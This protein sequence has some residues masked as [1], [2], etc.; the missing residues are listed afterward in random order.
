MP[1]VFLFLLAVTVALGCSC[2]DLGSPCSGL[3]SPWIVLAAK[4]LTNSTNIPGKPAKMLVEEPF[5]NVPAGL[6]EFLA[7]TSGPC[8]YGPLK[9]GERYVIYTHP[10]GRLDGVYHISMCSHTFAIRNRPRLL[11]ALRNQ[12]KGG[13]PRLIGRTLPVAYDPGR[14][15]PA[16]AGVTVT[17]RGRDI[18]QSTVSDAA[19]SY[20]FQNLRNG[21]YTIQFAKPGFLPPPSKE[22][23]V[24]NGQ[25]ALSSEE[26]A[27]NG[28]ISG[29]VRSGNGGPLAGIVVQAVPALRSAGP[30][31]ETRTR[32]DGSYTLPGLPAGRYAV[33]VNA[34]SDDQGP[35]PPTLRAAVTLSEHQALKNVDVTLPPP[36]TPARL[37]VRV[38][39]PGGRPYAGAQIS[40]EVEL[41]AFRGYGSTTTDAA[42]RADFNLYR[43][44]HYLIRA[45]DA[46]HHA[47]DGRTPLYQGRARVTMTATRQELVLQ[48]YP[49]LD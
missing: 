28:T 47:S 16:L 24:T 27:P 10:D 6:K 32:D 35:Y 38:L 22:I 12:L 21:R 23:E 7:D 13:P 9:A 17:L 18:L 1:V 25:C 37:R 48:L 19:G 11:E 30:F 41:P 5:L 36:R 46:P 2:N 3:R 34:G 15:A 45:F 4:A 33:G 42:G 44:E 39:W 31:R 40:A 20:E 43:G 14:D 29:I 49:T 26:L 8:E